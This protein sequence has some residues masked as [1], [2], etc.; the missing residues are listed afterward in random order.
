MRR[1]AQRWTSRAKFIPRNF[2]H[3]QSIALRFGDGAGPHKNRKWKNKMLNK[4]LA[5]AAMAAIAYA[6]CPA[7]AKG[8]G[9]CSGGNLTKTEAM[10]EAMA[11]GE[12]KIPAQ[13]EVALAQDAMLGGKMGVCAAHLNKAMHAGAA[14]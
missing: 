9:G 7:N 3:R 8:G 4:L 5:A 13:K 12:A 1:C 10:I 14:K 2:H 11:D 6:A